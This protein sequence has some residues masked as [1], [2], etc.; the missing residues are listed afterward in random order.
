[1]D[2][3]VI[4]QN[5]SG[6]LALLHSEYY[7]RLSGTLCCSFDPIEQPSE[8]MLENLKRS[9]YWLSQSKNER[10]IH[11]HC[12]RC[13]CQIFAQW[14]RNVQGDEK[15]LWAVASGTLVGCS[16]EQEPCKAVAE[17]N[18]HVGAEET[19]DGGM[20]SWIESI[21]GRQLEHV[22]L[23]Y[24]GANGDDKILFSSE[25]GD[26]TPFQ[27]APGEAQ[28]VHLVDKQ[29]AQTKAAKRAR[30]SEGRNANEKSE[31]STWT[32]LMTDHF[33][34][35]LSDESV[36]TNNED[37]G[38][39][40][41]FEEAW[42]SKGEGK[43]HGMNAP[44]KGN[45][46][47]CEEPNCPAPGPQDCLNGSCICGQVSFKI[48]R[49]NVGGRDNQTWQKNDQG[50]RRQN[51]RKSKLG[52]KIWIDPR[53]SFLSN[54]PGGDGTNLS[55]SLHYDNWWL[56][57]LGQ[58]EVSKYLA[59]LC[60]CAR[61]RLTTGFEIQAWAYVPKHNILIK[62]RKGWQETSPSD[63]GG[64]R[65]SSATSDHGSQ[66]TEDKEFIMGFCFEREEVEKPKPA[67]DKNILDENIDNMITDIESLTVNK[68]ITWAQVAAKA[69]SSSHKKDK[70]NEKV[71][72]KKVDRNKKGTRFRA[73]CLKCG[74]TCF[75]WRRGEAVVK[76]AVGL[77]KAAEGVKAEDWLEWWTRDVLHSE[78][79]TDGRSGQVAHR[80]RN[81]VQE[82]QRGL[83]GHTH[84]GAE[85]GRK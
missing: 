32:A 17:Y 26:T 35:D 82:C 85:R 9:R 63:G 62:H 10:I 13:G 16:D 73:F 57:P 7:R 52:E 34:C 49:P 83:R 45:V 36:E 76:V 74:A 59:T 72:E 79:A 20:S 38:D 24:R 81:L 54:E 42:N 19:G 53:P 40:I 12:G 31:D 44:G 23:R 50:R 29:T 70:G 30:K 3:Q 55:L 15:N 60:A 47:S 56:R 48:V 33:A 4:L 58:P 11:Y 43:P 18:Y 66:D 78:G 67:A 51:A 5:T 28:S 2:Q 68:Q 1:M 39:I 14:W 75:N 6:E 8:V 84:D 80:A 22:S 71:D 27:N 65:S 69:S 46:L 64:R 61:C 21:G 37:E 77:L 25:V 41:S